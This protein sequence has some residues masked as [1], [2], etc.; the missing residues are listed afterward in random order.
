LIGEEKKKMKTNLKGGFVF[1]FQDIYRDEKDS[2]IIRIRLIDYC[3]KS[4]I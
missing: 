4:S 2:T 1:Y 3:K